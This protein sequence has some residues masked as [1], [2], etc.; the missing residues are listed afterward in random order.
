[1]LIRFF[2]M[3]RDAGVPVSLTEFL[4]LLEALK[5]RVAS[6]SVDEFYFL[7]RTVLV[8]DER[9][10]DRYDRVFGA[11]FRGLEQAFQAL[12]TAALPEE[13]LRR[14]A[15]LLLTPEERA[16]VEALGGLEA[17]LDALKQR[18]AEQQGRH[19]GGNKWI[20]TAGRSPFG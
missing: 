9:H 18:L 4:A 17:L 5:A 13:W 6:L 20:G 7:A 19:E 1:M 8:K 16:K 10:Y 11:H 2:L 12:W 3:L 14:Q 15:E